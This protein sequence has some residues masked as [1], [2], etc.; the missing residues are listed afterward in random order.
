MTGPKFLFAD[1]VIVDENLVGVIVKS[2]ERME[3]TKVLYTYDVY[4]RNY[5]SI[6]P[7][8]EEDMERYRVRHKELEGEELDY[9][10]L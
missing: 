5:N 6:R 1:Q 2:W 7:Y 9:Q 10:N 8:K 4:V 3:S